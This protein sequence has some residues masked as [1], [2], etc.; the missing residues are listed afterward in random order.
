MNKTETV[1]LI[2]GTFA[3][4]EAQELLLELLNGKINFHNLKNWSSKER[5]GKPDVI[6]EQKLEY[7]EEARRNLKTLLAEAIKQQKSVTIN[8]IIEMKIED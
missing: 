3:P 2:K 4:E 5:F 8:S 1:N 7:L 6:S